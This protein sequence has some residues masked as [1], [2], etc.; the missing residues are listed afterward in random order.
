[1]SRLDAVN[2]ISTASP[3]PGPNEQRQVR[4]AETAK[5]GQARRASGR[6]NGQSSRRLLII[7]STSTR[8]R[9]AARS[10]P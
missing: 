3:S 9:S 6:A 4:G 1:M 8:R 2:F 10:I 5:T 7:A